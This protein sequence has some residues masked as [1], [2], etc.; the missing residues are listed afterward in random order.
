M[1]RPNIL[2]VDDDPANPPILK[3]ILEEIDLNFMVALS[4]PEALKLAE[5]YDFALAMMDVQMPGMNGFETVKRMRKSKRTELLPVVFVTA[6]YSESHYLIEGIETGAVDFISKPFNH[7]LLRGKV[8]VLVDLY[9]QRKK[10]ENEIAERK[11]AEEELRLAKET[12]ERANRH[13]SEFLAN[14]SHDIRTPMNAI[15]GMADLLS[16]TPLND[17]QKNYVRI[18][19]SAGQNLLNLINDILDLSKIER[20]Q[21]TTDNVVFDPYKIV[22]NT[23]EIFSIEAHKKGLELANC[24]H[25]NVPPKLIGD[26]ARLRQVLVNLIG[27]AVKFTH[28]GEIVVEIAP[29]TTESSEDRNSIELHFSVKDTGIGIRDDKL[30]A[31]FSSFRQADSSTTREYGGTGLGLSI[32]KRLVE[33]MGGRIWISSESDRGSTFHFTCRYALPAEDESTP[34]APVD[35]VEMKILAVD[36]NPTHRRIL[37]GIFADWK[38]EATLA[39]DGREAMSELQ[40]ACRENRPFDLVLIDNK[41]PEMDGFELIKSINDDPT[42][43]CFILMM[44]TTDNHNENVKRLKELG[45]SNYLPKPLK[46]T[47][48]KNKIIGI[49][50]ISKPEAK[51]EKME[52]APA[53]VA[54]SRPLNILMVD[55]SPDNRLLIQVFLKKTPYLLATAENGKIAVERFKTGNY[56]LVL[57]DMHMPVMDGYTATREIRKWEMENGLDRTRIIALTANAL[58]EDEQ[59]SLDAGCDTHLT[60][61]VTKAKLLGTVSESFGK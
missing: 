23:C 4:G 52:P 16:E 6:V 28:Q 54:E 60:K 39:A 38:A 18:F 25:S 11:L 1:E 21:I 2:L 20:D 36:D 61:P 17:E 46:R 45:I 51:G 40:S 12:A 8:K 5:E 43:E 48:L 41:M 24:I 50:D 7:N 35:L 26:P 32:S 14:M 29:A 27:N 3:E 53:K 15:L 44:L 9:R 57:M 37:K 13:K 42:L 34:D 30:D 55:D 31:V 33:K 47:E 22:E 59:K 10:L 19:R 58:K 49:L 56:D